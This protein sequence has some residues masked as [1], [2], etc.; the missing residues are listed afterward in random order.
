LTTA[1][2]CVPSNTRQS[3]NRRRSRRRTVLDRCQI[4]STTADRLC[5]RACRTIGRIW[6]A[7]RRRCADLR[8]RA[9]SVQSLMSIVPKG[10]LLISLLFQL[11]ASLVYGRF[12]LFALLRSSSWCCWVVE[13]SSVVRELPYFKRAM[14]FRVGKRSIKLQRFLPVCPTKN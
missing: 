2:C 3:A 10:L 4:T 6:T 1:D 13:G 8:V 7:T 12:D 9:D 5:R 11:C 14:R